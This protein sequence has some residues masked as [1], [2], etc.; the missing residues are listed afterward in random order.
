[1]GSGKHKTIAAAVCEHLADTYLWNDEADG[2]IGLRDPNK[3]APLASSSQQYW[4][5]TVDC[6]N[7]AHDHL[8]NGI[9][10]LMP[11]LL[12]VK[13]EESHGSSSM[14][15]ESI[16]MQIYGIH[17]KMINVNLCLAK[18]HL[19]NYFSSN[20]IHSLR[21]SARMLSDASAILA[22]LNIFEF[23]HAPGRKKWYGKNIFSKKWYYL[24]HY[25]QPG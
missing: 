4:K 13:K 23:H 2:D 3:P 11:I 9:K 16:S 19:Q 5:V 18:H 24:H 17:H 10:K 25:F 14:E 22:P 1:M 7:K 12:K 21:T 20:L 15:V 8:M 6:L